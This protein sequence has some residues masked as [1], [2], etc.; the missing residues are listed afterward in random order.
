M[1]R[2]L[3]GTVIS[4]DAESICLD[5]SGFGLEIF[6]SGSLLASAR[7]GEFLRCQTYMQISDAGAALYGFSDDTE[8]ALFLDITGVKTMGGKLSIA[9]LRHLET[10]AILRSIISGDAARLAVPGVGTKRAER[11]CFELKSKAEKKFGP[12]MGQDARGIPAGGFGGSVVMGLMGLGFSQGEAAGAVAQC[13]SD[14]G[15]RA[16]SEE[17]LMMAALNT[18]NRLQRS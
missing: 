13:R 8:R 5:V 1:I 10:D 7:V 16:L 2:S 12:L 9:I 15:D 11:I 17:E 4:A 6:A 3:Y 18:L 14:A